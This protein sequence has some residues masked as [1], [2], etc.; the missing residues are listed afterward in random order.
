MTATA[1]EREAMARRGLRLA[2]W[3]ARQPDAPAIVPADGD[4]AGART[5]AELDAGSNRVVRALRRR[6]LRV[7]D[8]VALACRNRAEYAEVADATQRAGFRLTPIN[9]HLTGDEAA[10]IV[11]DCG[12]RALVADA[13]VGPM[14][15]GAAAGAPGCDVRLAVGGAIDGFESYADAVA[16]EDGS[17][18][19]DPTPGSSMLY[20]S[21]TTGRPKGVH[22]PFDPA[23][24]AAPVLNLY[25]YDEDG[26]DVHLCTGPLYHA[27]P[28]AFSL[29]V[30]L[31]FGATV[32]L[33]ETWDAALAL[34]L[35]EQ[36][37]VTHTHMVATMFHRLLSLPPSVRDGADVS[38]L[39][40]VLHGAAP[41]PVP[42]KQALM[43]WWGPIVWEY[44]AATEGVGCFA[45]PQTWLD[46]PGTVGRPV[47]DD[48]V[49]VGSEAGEPLAPG[50]VGLVYIK[51]PDTGR[52]AYF[53]DTAKTDA[54]YRGDHFTLGDIGYMDAD[55]YLF[56]TDRSADLIISGGVNIYP[57]EVDAVLLTHPAVGD[58]ATI[59]VPDEEWGESV[60]S[61]VELQP[62]VAP[63]A[64]L[65]AS[66]IAHCR[67]RLAHFK[68]PRAVDFTAALPRQDNGKL[69]KRRLREQYAA[70]P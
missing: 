40:H 43:D 27:A 61:V 38:S 67:E 49:F 6:G 23:A 60:L 13:A 34:R 66:L 48:Q 14:A 41:C 35:I 54:A 36:H 33:M 58:A 65:A 22:R 26:G 28:L 3:A 68:C 15:V 8:A 25:G 52:F 11:A 37:G 57:A 50:E 31:A 10:Y 70:R 4:P 62:G 55:G 19:D 2:W 21:G 56:L 16:A 24:D 51:A 44:Y 42:V 39:R 30:P 53:G 69:Y 32:V 46:R 17:V 18:I 9:W 64:D 7:G 5:Y 1:D 47:P 29:Q 59:G 45:S 12:A 63:S 20:T